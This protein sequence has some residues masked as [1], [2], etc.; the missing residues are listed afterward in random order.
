MVLASC[1]TVPK[2][3]V[4]IVPDGPPLTSVDDSLYAH[5]L[6]RSIGPGGTINYAELADD[7]DLT[8]YLDQ[9]SRVR[10][11]AFVSR[12]QLLAFW[13]NTHNAYVLDLIRSN[14]NSGS[15]RSI[16]EIS[17]FHY[18]KVIVVDGKRYSLDGI[19]HEIIEKQFREPRAF[20]ALFDGSNSSSVL[21]QVPYNAIELSDQ[22]DQQLK[23]F[24][25]DSTKNYVDRRSNTLYLSPIFETYSTDLQEAAGGTLADFVRLFAPPEMA[26]WIARHPNGAISYVRYDHTINTNTPAPTHEQ[27]YRPQP[28]RD[29]GGIR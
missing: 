1:G 16:D 2:T 4:P 3:S 9:I 27:Y 29:D 22:L 28:R 18:A 11:D 20:F 26:S 24:L 25:A 6:E 12:A 8:T 14:W 13:I 15:V 21:H 10:I 23:S 5:V 7:T 19:E 17:G